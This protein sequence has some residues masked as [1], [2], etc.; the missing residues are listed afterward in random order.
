M[1]L[2]IMYG[3]IIT[4]WPAVSKELIQNKSSFTLQL[5]NRINISL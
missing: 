5:L 2:S 1:K 3:T 4:D